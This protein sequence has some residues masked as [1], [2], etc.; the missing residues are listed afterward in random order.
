LR[1]RDW[2]TLNERKLTSGEA[3]ET[4]KKNQWKG[5]S[6]GESMIR[7]EWAGTDKFCKV[8]KKFRSAK[9]IGEMK[10]CNQKLNNGSTSSV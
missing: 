5:S 7:G 8:G 6:S 2:R 1:Y 9:S 10:R 4:K 3:C